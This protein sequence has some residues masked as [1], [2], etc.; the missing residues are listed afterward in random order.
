MHLPGG[1][2]DVRD[3]ST[4]VAMHLVRRL[5]T[6]K[7]TLV[8]VGSHKNP[9][10]HMASAIVQNPFVGQKLAFFI[11]KLTQD[12]LAYVAE[13]AAAGTIRPVL[14]RTYP[15]AETAEAYR[16]AETMHARGKVVLTV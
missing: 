8:L 14:D 15:L 13:L 12:D 3:R 11:A 9:L 10:G 1:R 16:Y 7:G 6:P 2:A 5:L 4:T